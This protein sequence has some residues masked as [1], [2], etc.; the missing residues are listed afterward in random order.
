[1]KYGEIIVEKKEHELLRRIITMAHY[2]KDE[3]YK[4]SIEKLRNELGRAR[5]V[6]NKKMPE[7]VVRFNSMV[8][9]QTPFNVQKSYQVVTPEK[10]NIQENRI[11][12]LAPMGLAL[13]GYAKG[14]EILWQFPSGESAIKILEVEQ[15]ELV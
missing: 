5:I 2:Y 8:T 10:S 12:V 13:F 1:M 7:D 3:T 4:L 11:S 15:L 6:S 14:D 9:I